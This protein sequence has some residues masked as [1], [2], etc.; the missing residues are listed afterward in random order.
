MARARAKAQPKAATAGWIREAWG[1]VAFGLAVYLTAA[2][3]SYDPRLHW[4]DQEAQV[5]VVGLWIGWAAFRAFGHAGYLIPVA[6][7]VWGASAFYRPLGAASL[8]T[9]AGVGF[10]LV[11]LTGL[12]ARLSGPSAGVYLH[13]GGVLGRAV[14]AGLRRSV[15]DV[16]SLVVL[17]TLLAVAGLCLTHVSYAGLSRSLA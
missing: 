9:L 1:V 15:G 17:V 8:S 7:V 11:G 14:G 5:G 10:G 2:L 16:G 13:R 3:L 4:L 12:L 6:L